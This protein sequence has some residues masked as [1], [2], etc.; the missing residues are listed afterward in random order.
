MHRHTA[1]LLCALVATTAIFP[2]PAPFP[3][4][5]TRFDK[6]VD[7]LVAELRRPENRL[8]LLGTSI[9]GG[10]LIIFSS[11][12]KQLILLGTAARARLHRLVDDEQ[13]QNEVVLVLGAIGDE[14]TVPLLIGRYPQSLDPTDRRQT[15]MVC[16]SFA[17][18][19]LTGQQIDR[20]REGTTFDGGNARLWREWWARAGSTFRVSAAK[21]KGSWMPGY[22]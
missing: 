3:K 2:A 14:T 16:F 21:P 17:L 10:E 20:T 1:M 15:K 18:S 7:R 8:K 22:P 19:H 5:L 4:P 12:M 13:I 9:P 11:P 6:R